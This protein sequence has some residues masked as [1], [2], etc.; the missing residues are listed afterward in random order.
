MLKRF[1]LDET[2]HIRKINTKFEFP[3][4]LNLKHFCIE[5]ITK[6]FTKGNTGVENETFEIY[7]REDSYYEYELKGI[8]VHIG[9]FDGGHYFS[10]IDVNRDGKNNLLNEYPKENWLQFNDSRVSVFDT[11]TIPNECYG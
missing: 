3:K 1:Y 2:C 9:N 8:N 6:N 5:E 10:F 7:N 4:S 11:N